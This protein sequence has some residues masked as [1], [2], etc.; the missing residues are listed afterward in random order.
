MF[1]QC[2]RSLKK[3]GYLGERVIFLTPQL[4]DHQKYDFNQLK[5]IVE[6][7]DGAR[8]TENK[9]EATH[10]IYPDQYFEDNDED[11]LRTLVVDKEREVAFVHWWYYPS[12]Y[13]EWVP[14]KMVQG[15]PEPKKEPPEKW[16]IGARWLL[17]TDKFNEWIPEADYEIEEDFEDDLP[18]P[19]VRVQVHTRANENIQPEEIKKTEAHTVEREAEKQEKITKRIIPNIDDDEITDDDDEIQKNAKKKSTRKRARVDS[20]K[21]K[22]KATKD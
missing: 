14:L 19:Q 20:E 2:L 12:S 17:D 1:Q 7:L 8:L 21:K 15:E 3:R 10:I 9:D 22:F 13:D 4:S 5:H 6:R 18:Q 16:E 11:Y